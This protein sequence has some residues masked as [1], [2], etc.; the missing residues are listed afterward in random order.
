MY[1]LVMIK[2]TAMN[3]PNSKVPYHITEYIHEHFKGA[4]VDGVKKITDT[5]DRQYYLA[6][7]THNGITHWMKFD[8]QGFLEDEKAE[9]DYAYEK[10]E[11]LFSDT[12]EPEHEW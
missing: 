8:E 11:D 9:P 6:E 5:S 10:Q 12:D 2:T 1:L 7:V 3:T 4:L